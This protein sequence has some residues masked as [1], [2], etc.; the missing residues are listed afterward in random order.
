MVAANIAAEAPSAS[1]P[2]QNSLQ[3]ALNGRTRMDSM[4]TINLS[5]EQQSADA[6]AQNGCLHHED[7]EAMRL[8]GG[9]FSL[10]PCGY[11]RDSLAVYGL[12]SH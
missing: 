1:Y 5:Q 7:A 11:V 10:E 2:P 4:A 9:C 12:A 3:E 8:R 6:Q